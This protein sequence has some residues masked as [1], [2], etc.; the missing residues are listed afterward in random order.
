[1]TVNSKDNPVSAIICY[2]VGTGVVFAAVPSVISTIVYGIMK[3]TKHSAY[4]KHFFVAAA[5]VTIACW[6]IGLVAGAVLGLA[7]VIGNPFSR[8]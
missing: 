4:A 8:M 5:I 3:V 2:S 1:M 6:S 7:A